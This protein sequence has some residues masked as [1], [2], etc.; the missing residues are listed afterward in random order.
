MLNSVHYIGRLV[1]NPELR[2]T[3]AERPV[4]SFRIAVQRDFVRQG[5]VDTDFFDVIAWDKTAEFVC[6]H[7]SKGKLIC[8][9]GRNQNRHWE[10]KHGQKRVTTELVADRAYFVGDKTS[11]DKAV[12]SKG[13]DHLDPFDEDDDGLPFVGVPASPFDD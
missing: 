13:G 4:T 5:D 1:E 9:R 10:D 12:E 8:L 2:E 3:K 6:N 7:F 11:G